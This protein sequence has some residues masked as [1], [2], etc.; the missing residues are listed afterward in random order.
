MLLEFHTDKIVCNGHGKAETRVLPFCRKESLA[1]R[2][3]LLAE[4]EAKALAKKETEAAQKDA[5]TKTQK[6]AGEIKEQLSKTTGETGAEPGA[7]TASGTKEP[8]NH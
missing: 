1:L 3:Q 2:E 4:K 6:D 5:G 8:G 7:T